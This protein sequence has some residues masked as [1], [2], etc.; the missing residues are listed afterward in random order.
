MDWRRWFPH[1]VFSLLL[2]V[3]WLLLNNRLAV[4]TLVMGL[5]LGLILPPLTTRFW[6]AAPAMR[7]PGA[8]VRII[9]RLLIDM[10]VANL[11]VAALILRPRPRP[12]PAFVTYYLSVENPVA[13]T[14]LSS[15][16]SLTPGTVSVDVSRD[17]RRLCI[18][19]LDLDDE[20]ALVRRI[21]E[22]YERLLKEIFP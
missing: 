13:V 9:S 22:R 19:C 2:A 8:W 6:P 12:R 3:I 16:I 10:L 15:L 5:L 21:H 17:H 4:D 14:V 11:A 20:Q 7:H 18:H 1:P